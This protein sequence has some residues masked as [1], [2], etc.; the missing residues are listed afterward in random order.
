MTT[1]N[2]LNELYFTKKELEKQ[3]HEINKTIK[4]EKELEKELKKINKMIWHCILL[5]FLKKTLK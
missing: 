2:N 4:E 5:V 1:N 3:L